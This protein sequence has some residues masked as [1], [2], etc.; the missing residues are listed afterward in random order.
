MRRLS[1]QAAR[2]LAGALHRLLALALLVALIGA[3]LFAGLAW[4]LSQGPVELPWLAARLQ[5]AASADQPSIRVSI[6]R[7]ELAWAGFRL[8]VDQSLDI[9]LRDVAV[10]DLSRGHSVS[11]PQVDV[12]LALI[13]LLLGR[14]QPRT[15]EIVSP[16]MVVL[17]TQEGSVRLDFAGVD[18]TGGETVA[19][20]GTSAL[21]ALIR[22]LAR[23]P[24]PLFSQDRLER[25]SQLRQLRIRDAS[26]TVIDRQLKAVWRAQA[27]E[28]DLRRQP[29]GGVEGE[30]RF[31][32]KTGA[33]AASLRIAGSLSPSD[34]IIRLSARLSD[35]MP[36][37][38]ARQTVALEP[39]AA[40]DAR[41]SGT[42]DVEIGP[43]QVLR[44]IALDL[45]A[46]PGAVKVGADRVPI[47]GAD[48]A[49][50][51][52]DGDLTLKAFSLRLLPQEGGPVSTISGK[53][54][55][56]LDAGRW[57]NRFSVAVDHIG[58]AH[59]NRVW[60]RSVASSARAWITANITAG[61]V[62]D[63]N[64]EVALGINEDLSDPALVSVT[65]S[66]LGEGV[67]VHW[68]RPVPP[69]DRGN[70]RLN[71]VDADTFEIL[72]GSGR[73][74][75][76]GGR[77]SGLVIK[78]GRMRITGIS[79]KDQIS[80][81]DAVIAGPV[82]DAVTLLRHQRLHLFDN[83]QLTLDDPGGQF[84][85]TIAVD[86]PLENK[87][88][89][90]DVR[91]QTK[92]RLQNARFA[93]MVAGRNVEHGDIELA[94]GTDGVKLSGKAEIAGIATQLEAEMNFR[95]GPP[96]QVVRRI[97]ATARPT[98]RQ[99][100]VAGLDAGSALDG[101]VAM[102][103]V[104][105][106]RRDGAGDILVDADLSATALRVEPLGWSK[107]A[108]Q[109]ASGKARLKLR[110]GRLVG[111]D[112][113]AVDGNR[114]GAEAVQLRARAVLTAGQVTGLTIERATLG[115]SS[116]R[117][118]VQFPSAA[119]PIRVDLEGTDLD[120]APVLS[121]KPG[122]ADRREPDASKPGPAW[123]LDA[124]FDRV[125]MANATALTGFAVHAESDGDRLAVLHM[126]A[127]SEGGGS[128][129]AGRLRLDIDTP[130]G[131]RVRH[132][133]ATAG[134]AGDLLR[135]VDV[136]HTMQGGRLSVT[137]T[138]DDNVADHPLT[139]TAEIEDFRIQGAPALGRLLQAMTLY[140]LVDVMQGSGLG[141]RR[142][143]A[144]FRLTHDTLV[145]SNARAFSPSLGITVKGRIDL[146]RDLLDLEGTIVPAYFFNSLLGNLPLVG[147][148]FSP[149]EGGGLF[150]ASYKIRG[151][152]ND[153][154]VAVNPLSTLTPGF[155]R[156]VFGIF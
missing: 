118:S 49:M 67:T 22:E 63:G 122:A 20:P 126:E 132:L 3:V 8:G 113:I 66:L 155:L 53:G 106:E 121:S 13:G 61:V 71:I 81:I 27:P 103:A 88:E 75:L 136:L 149:E 9:R 97:V 154:D 85:G 37:A 34:G 91:I 62:R 15:L 25:F 150:A 74:S 133:S 92:L 128:G 40:M 55:L 35:F 119:G 127:R 58:F 109:P 42:L 108:G 59:L 50:E 16:R 102:K 60:P 26:L 89:I 30:S 1:G 69:I 98:S 141:F 78:S 80:T 116:G 83:L 5:E 2:L 24:A 23:P 123:S 33:E 21:A 117:G 151:G 54:R 104:I 131:S 112:D 144:P 64:V 93:G 48:L 73:Q 101:N 76:E 17:R 96:S 153:P 12:S 11:V 146:A 114:Q 130:A 45:H 100:A 68:L 148:L 51:G 82:A 38:L 139:G 28:I 120:L 4:R 90:E 134:N 52:G 99:L 56:L 29:R 152:T 135:S 41:L 57:N 111:I 138:Y 7:A 6:G 125:F 43:G 140:G 19:E 107:P 115:R 46:G 70:A 14:I 44:R 39:L 47:A 32:L 72:V 124:R 147:K 84:S 94:A 110:Q 145:L 77:E 142:L 105:T 143:V 95:A 79:Q 86:L 65:G 31:D 87:L 10:R 129:Q 137:G 156:G 36:G 18:A